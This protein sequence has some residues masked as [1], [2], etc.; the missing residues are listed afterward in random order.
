MGPV[1][2]RRFADQRIDRDVRHRLPAHADDHAAGVCDFADDGEVE[3]PLV[4][5]G[6]GCSF[7]AGLEHHQHPLLALGE[8]DFIRRHAGFAGRHPV[9]I[10]LDADAALGRHLDGGGGQAR[11]AH[12]LD[13]HDGVGR[14]QLQAGLQQQFLGER[15]ADLHGRALLLAV[16]LEGRRGHG[17]AVNAVA[18]GLGADIDHRIARAGRRRIEDPVGRGDAD[19][20]GVDQDIAVIGRVEIAFAA[21]CRHAHAVAVAG[22][23]RHHAGH[24]MARFRMRRIA[25]A[26]GVQVGDRPGAH[27]EH[28]A[29]DAADAGR[30]ALVG[31]DEGRVVVALDLEDAGETLADID[32]AGVLARPLDDV[33]RVGWQGLQ[34][35]FRGFV[36]AVLGPHDREDAEF[37]EGRFPA[38]DGEDSLVLFGRQAVPGDDFRRDGRMIGH[39]AG[40]GFL[41]RSSGFT[42][43]PPAGKPCGARHIRPMRRASSP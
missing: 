3:L 17:R 23:P 38:H 33:G 37:G 34:P 40:A 8:Q 13:R 16:V 15:V 7:P 26:Q 25:E 10:E 20:H 24:Q 39:A 22:D 21:H 12:V 32:D 43:R 31:L 29:H 30:R 35:P 5:D 18:P 42:F 28:V 1:V 4:E 6:A 9:Q 14:H 36:R 11:R 41:L 27:G 19:G 2:F